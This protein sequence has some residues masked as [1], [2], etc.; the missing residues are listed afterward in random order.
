MTQLVIGLGEVGS[1]VR[2]VLECDGLDLEGP[3]KAQYDALHICFPYSECFIKWV[4]T[5]R[6]FFGAKLVVVHST[7]PLGTCRQLKA[8]SSP[9]RGVHPHLEEGVRTF[10]KFFGGPQ[11]LE[12]AKLFKAK[13]VKTMCFSSERDTEA[14][15]LWDTT[16]YGWNILIEKA[17]KAYCERHGLDFNAVY[18]LANLTYNEGYAALGR[19]EYAKYVLK[20]FPGPIGGHCVRENW[21]LLDDPIAEL[22]K[23][24]HKRFTDA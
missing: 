17:I 11:A 15:K 6:R 8:V 1:A 19:R 22:S 16:I 18:K 7:V 12:A 21:E 24:L 9:V 10:V 23:N 13:G 20:D 2:A 3:K 5:Y 4:R 14:M